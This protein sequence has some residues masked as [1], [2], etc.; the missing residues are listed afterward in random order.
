[1]AQFD[2]STFVGK[3]IVVDTDGPILYVGHLEKAGDGQL[4]LTDVD[5]HYLQDGNPT[6]TNELYVLESRKHGVRRNRKAAQIRL[7]RVMS[8][9]LLE[10]IIDF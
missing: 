2:L 5:V 1:M 3:K 4:T 6:T 9:S 8:V 7:E 10:D